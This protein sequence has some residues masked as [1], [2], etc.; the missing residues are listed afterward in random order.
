MGVSVTGAIF[1]LKGDDE[2]VEM[3]QE[4]YVLEAFADLVGDLRRAEH[5]SG[6]ATA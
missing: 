5:P 2:L 1:V 4:G 3:R 6:N